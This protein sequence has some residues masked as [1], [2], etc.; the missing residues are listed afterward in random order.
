MTITLSSIGRPKRIENKS[1][2]RQIQLFC[3]PHFPA[4]PDPQLYFRGQQAHIQEHKLICIFSF[5]PLYHFDRRYYKRTLSSGNWNG[6]SISKG[7]DIRFFYIFFRFIGKADP[8]GSRHDR[9]FVRGVF[10]FILEGD[11]NLLLFNECSSLNK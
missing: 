7:D 5:Y 10:F 2:F 3:S 11:R 1:C 8:E 6:K 4:A 9:I